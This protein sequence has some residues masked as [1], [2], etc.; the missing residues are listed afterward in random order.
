M[1]MASS[2]RTPRRCCQNRYDAM[3]SATFVVPLALTIADEKWKA[4]REV[5]LALFIA[6]IVKRCYTHKLATCSARSLLLWRDRLASRL[7]DMHAN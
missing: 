5:T 7:E 2:L 3:V 6:V 4:L 1:W